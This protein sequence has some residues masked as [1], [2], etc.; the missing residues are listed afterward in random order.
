MLSIM[1]YLHPSLGKFRRWQSYIF[2]IFSKKIGSD[3]SGKL[4]P[5]FWGKI[6]K[7]FQNVIC[8]NFYP[9]WWWGW[10]SIIFTVCRWELPYLHWILWQLNF[11]PYLSYNFN[12]SVWLLTD[13]S[14]IGGWVTT[15]CRTWCNA[16]FCSI[17]SGSTMFAQA[18]LF[19]Y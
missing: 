3:I 15:P 13:E 8:W 16:T 12:K 14:K 10:S 6:R 9:A 18:Y 17:W 19:Q 11:L 1:K 2:L 5:Y 4:S 7:I